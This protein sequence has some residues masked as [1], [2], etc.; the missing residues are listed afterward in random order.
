[1][2]RPKL[3]QIA[4]LAGAV[5]LSGC[6]TAP[7]TTRTTGIGLETQ[8]AV[9]GTGRMLSALSAEFRREVPHVI[10]FD[11]DSTVL[12]AEAKRRLDAQVAWIRKHANVRFAVTGHA[13]RVG[14]LAYNE[15]LGLKRAQAAVEYMVTRGVARTQLVA[16]I[17]EGETDPV[18]ATEARERANRRVE[19]DV[20]ELIR[21]DD[22]AALA[23]LDDATGS[24]SG[25]GGGSPDGNGGGTPDGNGGG[26]PD[27]NGGGTPDG[28]GGGTP[29]GN[30][31]GNGGGSDD[32]GGGRDKPGKGS[33][34]NSG[35][36]N[37]DEDRD[38]G[39]SGGKNQGGDEL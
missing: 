24:I 34:A 37:G 27:G 8:A 4:L 23:M 21:E 35:R 32:N 15:A 18:I 11:F 20:L 5:A 19:T 17:S 2:F 36:G 12:D 13:D 6:A 7:E 30:G 26:T 3:F 22:P 31:G 33:Q 16:M 14:N 39:K 38:P 29:D 10:N 9:R 28:N 25:N 1:M